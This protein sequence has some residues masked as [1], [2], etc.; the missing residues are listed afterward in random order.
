MNHLKYYF[1]IVFLTLIS[2]TYTQ[3]L[4]TPSPFLPFEANLSVDGYP[5]GEVPNEV[6]RID[7]EKILYCTRFSGQFSEYPN[8]LDFYEDVMEGVWFKLS[9]IDNEINKLN[10][11]SPIDFNTDSITIISIV[12]LSIVN[13]TIFALTRAYDINEHFS[14][15]M[16]KFDTTLQL[17]DHYWFERP[18]ENV[19]PLSYVMSVRKPNGNYVMTGQIDAPTTDDPDARSDYVCEFTSTGELVKFNDDIHFLYTFPIRGAISMLKNGWFVIDFGIIL[20]ENLVQKASWSSLST[21]GT[22]K[23]FISIDSSTFLV[24]AVGDHDIPNTVDD[25]NYEAIFAINLEGEVD[26]VFYN[27]FPPSTIINLEAAADYRGLSMLDTNNIFFANYR[28]PFFWELP[29]YVAIRSVQL[30]GTVNWHYYFGGDA[31]YALVDVVPMPDGGCLLITWKIY[32]NE[33]DTQ[34]VSDYAYVLIG[35]D[36][37]INGVTATEEPGI[38]RYAAL[39]YPNPASDYI[40]IE[41]GQQL[42]EVELSLF[43]ASGKEVL[44]EQ[45][46]HQ[47]LEVGHLPVGSYFYTLSSKKELVQSG[48]VMIQR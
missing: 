12:N 34:Y 2:K 11:W 17:L 26:T 47:K 4:I 46:N 13:D 36:G 39:L 23:R 32:R 22:A 7:D 44:T 16:I 6:I 38:Q 18:V 14:Y 43:D 21:F 5:L 30:N 20:D 45:L 25:D 19:Y 40:F 41:Y 35:E 29:S 10:E 1:F 8:Q 31:A 48:Q 42:K 28:N 37:S 15:C 3:E 24:G 27:H 33:A 9:I